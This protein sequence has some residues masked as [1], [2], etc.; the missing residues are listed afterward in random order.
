MSIIGEIWSCCKRRFLRKARRAN[1]LLCRWNLG[2]RQSPGLFLGD[3]MDLQVTL[4]LQIKKK[5]NS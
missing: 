4:L 3:G 5:I 2:S 1:T